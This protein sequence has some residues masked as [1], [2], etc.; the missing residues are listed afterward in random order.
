VVIIA[1]EKYS[2]KKFFKAVQMDSETIR[3]KYVRPI[4]LV[5]G[6]VVWSL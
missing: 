4:G 3:K 2:H 5:E 1:K 6:T